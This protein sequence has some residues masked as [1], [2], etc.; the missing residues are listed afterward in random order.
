VEL[1]KIEQSEGLVLPK[2]E[3]IPSPQNWQEDMLVAPTAEEY[4]P[5]GQGV[6]VMKPLMSAPTLA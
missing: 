2:V 4:E 3:V 5:A 6:A 1:Q